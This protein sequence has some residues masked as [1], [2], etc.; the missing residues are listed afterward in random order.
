MKNFNKVE[1]FGS[2]VLTIT[3]FVNRAYIHI[4]NGNNS[5]EVYFKYEELKQ[6]SDYLLELLE[7]HN[8]ESD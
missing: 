4:C 8:N 7:Q 6:L 2:E 5:A 3:P 1:G